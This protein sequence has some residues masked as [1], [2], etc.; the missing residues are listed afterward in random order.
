MSSSASIS[1]AKR[2][3]GPQPS[4]APNMRD[5]RA[6][7]QQSSSQQR[8]Q[9]I[10]PMAIL[11]NHELRLRD[12]EN[13]NALKTT[14]TDT[15]KVVSQGENKKID[16]LVL[17]N[18]VLSKKIEILKDK[19]IT[20]EKTAIDLQKLKDIVF[21]LQASVIS[22]TNKVENLQD[23]NTTGVVSA[24][25]AKEIE[26]VTSQMSTATVA[27]GEDKNETNSNVTEEVASSNVTFTVVENAEVKDKDKEQQESA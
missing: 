26:D 14:D 3:R 13:A 25:V 27:Y 21:N 8:P 6:N 9:R 17:E 10:H 4:A 19:I 20:L 7:Q 18:G 12:I 15:N 1:A 11:E 24:N 16:A 2:R 23:A 5:P 22:N